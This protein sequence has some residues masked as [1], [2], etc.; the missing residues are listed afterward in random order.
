MLI[1][2]V[3]TRDFPV[4]VCQIWG[5]RYKSFFGIEIKTFPRNIYIFRNGFIDVYRN[6]PTVNNEINA[7]FRKKEKADPIFFQSFYEECLKKANTLKKFMTIAEINSDNLLNFSSKLCELWH[8]LYASMNIPFDKNSSQTAR[9][10]SLKLRHEFDKLE[11][12]FFSYINNSLIKIFPAL[13]QFAK[14][15]LW[16][17]LRTGKIPSKLIIK[18]RS[19]KLIIL[20]DKSI[21]NYELKKLEKKCD[22]TLETDKIINDITVF[23][24]Q[25][26]YPGKTQGFVRKILKVS[27]VSRLKKNEILV[28]YMTVPDFLPAMV[29]AGAFVTDEG[30]IT[31]HAAIVAREMK[32]PCVIGTK[33][34]TKILKD[35]DQVEVDADKGMIR[36]IKKK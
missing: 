17:E 22:F 14:Y 11:Y 3:Y 20:D 25:T 23:K 21:S 4:L 31:C 12:Q 34:A 6:I 8:G 18:N 15:I 26:A 35:G 27:H 36:I 16:E 5:R 7:V 19:N 1:K 13:G 32:K 9:K 29:K 24:G 10:L 30:G 2:K 28:S 33:V